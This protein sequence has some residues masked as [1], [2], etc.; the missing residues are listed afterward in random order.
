MPDQYALIPKYMKNFK[1]IG[2]SC[3]DTC[4]SLWHISID[5]KS[6][7]QYVSIKNRAWRDKF[8]ANITKTKKDTN[9]RNYALMN[10]NP[11]TGDCNML[12]DGLC[13]IQASL[14]ENFL[15]NTCATYP[16]NAN[17]LAET[18]EI[19]ATPSCPEAARLILLNPEGIEFVQADPL[20]QSNLH[21]NITLDTI[22]DEQF[23]YFWDIRITSIEILQNREFSL[24]HRLLILGWF[25]DYIT[26]VKNK[27]APYRIKNEISYFK[28]QLETNNE[29]RDYQ[30]FPQNEGFQLSFLNR[31]VM[32]RAEKGTWNGRYKECLGEY[33]KGLAAAEGNNEKIIE[34]Y[35]QS[36]RDYYQ[37]YMDTHEYILENYLVNHIFYTLFPFESNSTIFEQFT[38][39]AINYSIIKL[40]LIGMSSYHKGLNDDIVVKLI[41]SYSKNYEHNNDFIVSVREE[42]NKKQYNT[43]GHLSLLIKN[44]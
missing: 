40:H 11:E 20:L 15:C 33:I 24:A 42:L 14:G 4:C 5:K 28:E 26:K 35:N 10:L 22:N 29:L 25:C 9:E 34:L 12:E 38:K 3:E 41:Q 1:C 8:K 6:Y 2:S 30:S 39:I 21:Y 32:V 27:D 18:Q 13:S 17:R 23:Q 43:I 7:D 19:S 44:G 31:L 16:R 36:Y 37:P